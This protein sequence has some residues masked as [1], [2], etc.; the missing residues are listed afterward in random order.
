[1]TKKYFIWKDSEC[2]GMNPEWIELTGEEFYK[3]IN[4]PQNSGRKFIK[5]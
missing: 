4:T 5:E 1:M 2:N 3:F